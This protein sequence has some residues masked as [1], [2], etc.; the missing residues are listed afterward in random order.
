ML[1][2]V[3]SRSIRA[4]MTCSDTPAFDSATISLTVT[5]EAVA[6][7]SASVRATKT[8]RMWTFILRRVQRARQADQARIVRMPALGA[9]GPGH[10]H[11]KGT[12]LSGEQ[13]HKAHIR[14]DLGL[15]PSTQRGYGAC[16]TLCEPSRR[17]AP[18]SRIGSCS[19]SW[20]WR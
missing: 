3:W 6:G 7:T 11:V 13:R 16:V 18:C 4:R 17:S 8:A 14:N 19:V 20:L 12:V 15:V 1:K 2:I 9:L 10:I 5:A